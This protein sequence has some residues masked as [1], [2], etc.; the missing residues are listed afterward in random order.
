MLYIQQNVLTA[1]AVCS[2]LLMLFCNAEYVGVLFNVCSKDSFIQIL[3]NGKGFSV[4]KDYTCSGMI[5]PA[6]K[7]EG[8]KT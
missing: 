4:L 8:A 6:Y 2:E 1:F 7:T 3:R 5:D